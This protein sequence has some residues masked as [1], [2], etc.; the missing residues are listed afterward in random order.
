MPFTAAQIAEQVKG[1]VIGDS[2]IELRGLAPAGSARA[3]DLTFAEKESYFIAAEQS[4]ASAIL[5]SGPFTSSKKVLI[6]VANARIAMARL[7][8]LFFPQE[9]HSPGIDPSA[10]IDPLAQIHPTAHV[11]PHCVVRPGVRVGAR[12]VLMAGNY[13]GQGSQIGDD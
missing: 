11:G 2:S 8:P 6:H 13:I 1:E 9:V 3:G 5:V 7:L 4:D 12:S 10:V